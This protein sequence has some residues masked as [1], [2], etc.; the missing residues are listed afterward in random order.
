MSIEDR[1]K[2]I[3]NKAIQIKSNTWSVNG[4]KSQNDY[5]L[6]TIA[7]L[8]GQIESLAKN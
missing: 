7:Q 4:G 6:L 1:F 3:K 2:A 5:Y 8:A